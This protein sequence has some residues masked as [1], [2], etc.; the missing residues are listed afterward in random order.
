MLSSFKVPTA[1]VR[2]EDHAVRGIPEI[3]GALIAVI[4]CARLI[5]Q[6]VLLIFES[7]LGIHETFLRALIRG[8]GSRVQSNALIGLCQDPA[9]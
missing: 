8:V 7:P 4:I 9:I 2:V 5:T 6:H 3:V 1:R